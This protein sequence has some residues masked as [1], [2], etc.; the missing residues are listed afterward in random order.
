VRRG[1]IDFDLPEPWLELNEFGE[2][3]GVTRAPATSRTGCSKKLC[4]ARTKRFAGHIEAKGLPMISDNE[5]AGFQNRV[6]E[7]EEARRLWIFSG[8]GA[9]PVN[10]ISRTLRAL[11]KRQT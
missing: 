8:R 7:F 1:S 3:V 9:V 11:D 5:R 4:G 2:M 6:M 10:K